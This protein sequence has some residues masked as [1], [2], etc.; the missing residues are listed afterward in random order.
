[1]AN[2]FDSFSIKDL[3]L[4][5][6]VVMPPMC[7]YCADDKGYPTKWHLVHYT[8]RAVGG[9]GLI[10]LE[11]TAIDP[12]GRISGSDLGIWEDSQVDGLGK[13][14]DSV[15][16]YGSKIGIQLNHAGRKCEAKGEKI[17]APSPISYDDQSV[18]PTEM[19]I[20]DI[21][22]TINAFAKGAKRARL[23]GF[24]AI[25]IHAAHGYLI[26]QFLSPLTNKRT[27]DY[28]GSLEN[29]TRVLKEVILAVREYWP[30]EKPLLVRITAEDYMEGG[31]LAK[32]LSIVINSV[33]N[34]GVDLVDVSTGGVVPVVPKTY[35]GY[36]VSH[37]ETI[38]IQTGLPVIG[39]GL[40]TEAQMANDL[41]ESNKMDLVY[42]GREQL[43]NPYF[44]LSAARELDM[45]I[46]WPIQY[47]RAKQK[48][49]K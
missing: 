28:G 34:Y 15:K 2:L 17:V 48:H 10:I 11:A 33:K 40:I 25:E 49:R 35:P 13:L 1:M 21:N 29:R 42:V 18:I 41:I 4:R 6:R 37:A 22:E 36:Q 8:S 5:N 20:E 43:R 27:D 45:D 3:T 14:V 47:E 38:K 16:S 9:T 32:D 19:S 24:D 7:M 12:A 31:N 46:D 26:N 30:A 39:G 44:C 23:A